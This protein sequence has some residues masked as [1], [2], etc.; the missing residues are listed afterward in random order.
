M[1]DYVRT[2]GDTDFLRSSWPSVKQAY[3][4][5]AGKD[6]DGDGLMDLKGAGLGALEFGSL[7][8]I[9]ADVYTCGVWVQAIKDMAMMAAIVDDADMKRRGETD[10]ARASAAFETKFW[11][12][13]EGYYTYGATEKGEQVREKTPWSGVA[14]M[15]GV[16]RPD[17]AAAT[18]RALSGADVCTDWGVRSLARSSPLFEPANYNYGAVWPFIGSF[19]NTA[20]FRFGSPVAAYT[21]LRSTLLHAFDDGLGLM[22]EVYSGELNLKL[23]EAYHHQGFSTTGYLLPFLR[24]LLGLEVDALRN[25]ITLRPR[26]P[27]HWREVRLRNVRAGATSCDLGITQTDTSIAVSVEAVTGDPCTLRFAPVPPLLARRRGST[28]TIAAPLAAGKVLRIGFTPVP[29]LI[30]PH[31]VSRPGDANKFLRIVSETADPRVENRMNIVVEGRS[32]Q[33]YRIRLQRPDL[34]SATSGALLEGDQLVVDFEALPSGTYVA[35][36][37]GISIRRQ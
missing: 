31:S 4:W 32:G 11:M 28:D 21:V 24:G 34:I 5:C 18:I 37:I 2:S 30:P 16:T 35:R 33:T 27:A 17:R 29:R 7:V 1:A 36:E 14:L 25:T 9:Y 26:L 8:G 6:S 20:Q 15:F 12:E 10:L 3:N 22:P 19:F 23:G 13:K